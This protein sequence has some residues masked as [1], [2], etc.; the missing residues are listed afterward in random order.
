MNIKFQGGANSEE[1]QAELFFKVLENITVDNPVMIELGSNDAYYSICFNRFFEEKNKLNICVEVSKN[2]L[3]LGKENSTN[4]NCKD[5]HFLHSKVGNIDT[6]Y[7]NMISI[8]EPNL[9]GEMAEVSISITDI[10]NKFNI[11]NISLLHMDIQ[12]SEIFVLEEIINKNISVDYLFVSTH[13]ESS[14]GNTY[15]KCKELLSKRVSTYLF[16]SEYE[17]GCGDGLIV[18]KLTS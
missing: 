10:I 1:L 16:D 6:E 5:I 8:T 4:N 7:F 17:G 12:G 18:C 11:N 15:H 3:E 13:L 9:W 2:L 14:F